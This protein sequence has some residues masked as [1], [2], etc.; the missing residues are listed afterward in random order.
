MRLGSLTSLSWD[1]MGMVDLN[2]PCT[3]AQK[4]EMPQMQCQGGGI[5][6]GRNVLSGSDRPSTNSKRDYREHC[7]EIL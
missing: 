2:Q 5:P 7:Q 4:Q 6:T 3:L 1:P